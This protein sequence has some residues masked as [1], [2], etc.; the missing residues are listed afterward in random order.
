MV[1]SVSL[2]IILEQCTLVRIIYICHADTLGDLLS[3]VP[4]FLLHCTQQKKSP[5][6]S[7]IPALQEGLTRQPSPTYST[8][9]KT[10]GSYFT[11]IATN[12]Q[13]SYRSN[14]H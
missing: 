3:M 4:I 12:H 9:R 2:K 6:I 1:L 8:A 10:K 13:A 11:T 7:I 5:Q 14:A